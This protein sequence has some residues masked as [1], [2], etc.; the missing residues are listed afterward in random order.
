MNGN[1][2]R[3]SDESEQGF[4]LVVEAAPNAW[5]WSAVLVKS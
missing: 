3:G 2:H 1:D 4:R 5:G